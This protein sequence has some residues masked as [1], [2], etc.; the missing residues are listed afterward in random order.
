MHFC[1]N[2]HV[3]RLDT[4]RH[5]KARAN[6]LRGSV[7]ATAAALLLCSGCVTRPAV[8][9]ALSQDPASWSIHVQTLWGSM[10][11]VRLGTSTNQQHN[12]FQ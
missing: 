11:Y 7:A 1:E 12:P 3:T 2:L 10:D 9:K 5:P 8:L 6:V 4:P